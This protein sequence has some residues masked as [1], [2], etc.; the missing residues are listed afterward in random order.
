MERDPSTTKVM[1][2]DLMAEKATIGGLL[3]DNNALSD[4]LDVL[5]REASE[6]YHTAHKVIF[7]AIISLIEKNTVA[8]LVT[9]ST[10]L[11]E[12]GELEKAGGYVFLSEIMDNAIS[13][14]NIKHYAKI[15]K[16]KAIERRIISESSRLIEA[17]YNPT[18]DTEE[19]LSEAQKTILS[20]SLAREKN[21]MKTAHDIAKTTAKLIEIRHERKDG[22]VIGL[23]TR[24]NELDNLTGGLM[25]GDLWIVAAR[26]GMGKSAFAVDIA[27]HAALKEYNAAIFSLEMPTENLMIRILSSMTRIDSR[28]LSRGIVAKEQ[29]PTLMEAI[30]RIGRSPLVIDDK[31]GITP[32]EILAKCRRLKASTGLDLIVVDYLQLM[33]IGGKYGSR[34][35]EVAEISRN[36]KLIAKELS[37]PVIALSQLNRNLEGR[38]DKRPNLGDLRESGAIE[39]DADVVAF[40][41]RDEMYH[42]NSEEKGVAEIIIGK[43]RNGPTGAVKLTF[44]SQFTRFENLAREKQ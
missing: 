9:I 20:L 25:N 23:P 14:A 1:P 10:E 16:A 24:F 13:A 3:M 27:F 30:E 33:R 32:T 44:Q 8:D 7:R 35:Q 41:Y 42:D 18:M 11:T 37:V 31:A 5:E 2:N 22:M 34:E 17:A 28:L 29:W 40:I 12:R 21:T 19:K 15:V 38:P 4:V 43:H 6:F 36:M 26:P 39:Q